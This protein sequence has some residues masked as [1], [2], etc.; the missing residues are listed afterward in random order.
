[1]RELAIEYFQ[2]LRDRIVARV[3][4]L[5]GADFVRKDWVRP[6]GGGGQMSEL[7]GEVIEKGGCNFSAVWGERYPTVPGSGAQGEGK[8]GAEGSGKAGANGDGAALAER[9][10]IDELL[11]V[12]PPKPEELAGKPFFATGVSLVMHPKNPFV[13][14]VHM[15]VRYF[16]AG[17]LA[18]FGGGLDLTPCVPF[19]EDTRHFH[20]TL[21][22]TCD[23][24]GPERY[25]RFS[26]WAKDYFFIQHRNS[27]RGVGGI[28][29]DY[30]R[31]DR[32]RDFE[33]VQDVGDSFLNAWVPLVLRRKGTPVT[34]EDRARQLKW[35]GRYVEFNLVYDR[36]TL[37]GLKTGGNIEAIFM[38]L[39]PL[40]AW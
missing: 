30:L 19:D 25:P 3:A 16:E 35:R 17:D 10:R 2:G 32:E 8:S 24:H 1:M 23:A 20:D 15:N 29:F 36:G 33:F 34:D 11:G 6:E 31:R 9:A 5:D 12:R 28:F 26:Q 18:W 4:A 7:R 37:F 38:S 22:R 39:P 40:V 27:E 14:V 21:K 13:P